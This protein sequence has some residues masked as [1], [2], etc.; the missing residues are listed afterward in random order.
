M[1]RKALSPLSSTI[2]L[3]VISII[4]GL[5]VM[6]WGR[7]YVEQ[8]AAPE[9]VIEEDDTLFEDLNERLAKGEITQ[10]QYDQIKEV[11]LSQG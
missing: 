5:V 7:S 2:I 1:N 3:L 11:L 4:I 6:T 8:V 10:G 9:V